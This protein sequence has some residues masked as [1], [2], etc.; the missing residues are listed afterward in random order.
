MSLPMPP[1]SRSETPRDVGRIRAA[2]AA[3]H[4]AARQ[5][6]RLEEDGEP[7]CPAALLRRLLWELAALRAHQIDD[8]RRL[9]HHVVIALMWDV[10]RR[11]ASRCSELFGSTL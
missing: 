2:N 7:S 8:G 4:S 3:T 11:T 6:P 10:A 1:T 5:V 9:L